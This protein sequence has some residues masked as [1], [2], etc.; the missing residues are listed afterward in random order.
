L[1]AK[2]VTHGVS[3]TATG[4]SEPSEGMPKRPP[5]E[6]RPPQPA[7][8]EPA[9]LFDA[10]EAAQLMPEAAKTPEVLWKAARNVLQKL[11]HDFAIEGRPGRVTLQLWPEVEAAGA[12]EPGE[13]PT[14]ALLKKIAGANWPTWKKYVASYPECLKI[15]GPG[16]QKVTAEAILGTV[17]GNHNGAPRVDFVLYRA[18]GEYV[19]LHPGTKRDLT[20]AVFYSTGLPKNP[21]G[22]AAFQW[23]LFPPTVPFTFEIAQLVPQQDQWSKKQ[24]HQCL[25]QLQD[26][27]QLPPPFTITS[28]TAA[29]LQ[30]RLWVANAGKD[31]REIIGS[32]ILRA[33]V[34]YNSG[35]HA[36]LRFERSGQNGEEKWVRVFVHGKT[37]DVSTSVRFGYA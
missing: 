14:R 36:T 21:T 27:Q 35:V 5:P 34:I 11:S 6:L 7:F 2:G 8:R 19:R 9:I 12:T 28:T 20:A 18:D 32:G 16:I 29:G 37:N 15:V 24:L 33:E 1:P 30:W 22:N 25:Q 17:D 26:C 4:A 13:S 23:L 10:R 3:S 31:G